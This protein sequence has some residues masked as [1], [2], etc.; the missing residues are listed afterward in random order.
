MQ[1][2]A[3]ETITIAKR[4]WFGICAGLCPN[5]DVTVWADGRVLAVRHSWHGLDEI[6]RFRV[7]RLE[8]ARFRSILLPYR[9]IAIQQREPVCHH[10]V[11]QEQSR[12]VLKVREVELL[13]SSPPHRSR[14]IACDTREL[15]EALRQ[16]L[17]AVQVY[18]DGRRITH[19]DEPDNPELRSA[20]DSPG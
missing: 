2:A 18:P 5:Y 10:D 17:R 13:W 6:E 11:P 7:S 16:A 1:P 3:E 19:E 8:A 12:L 9:P 15:S 4:P 20:Y 14:L